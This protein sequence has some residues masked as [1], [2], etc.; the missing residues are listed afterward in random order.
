M[1]QCFNQVCITECVCDKH[2]TTIP[3]HFRNRGQMMH[4]WP[5]RCL[6]EAESDIR[7]PAHHLYPEHDIKLCIFPPHL[8]GCSGAAA[9]RITVHC[10]WGFVFSTVPAN[11][12][13]APLPEEP[14]SLKATSK[15][16]ALCQVLSCIPEWSQVWSAVSYGSSYGHRSSRN[17][18]FSVESCT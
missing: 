14:M 16:L 8:R 1:L 7:V 5:G 18:W 6:L 12:T 9:T 11:P 3:H 10:N 15:P 2:Q 4:H 17:L 13:N